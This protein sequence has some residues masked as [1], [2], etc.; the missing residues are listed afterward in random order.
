VQKRSGIPSHHFNLG[1][2]RQIKECRTATGVVILS[3]CIPKIGSNKPADFF[4][5]DCSGGHS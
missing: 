3:L 4:S 5:E 1:P 2:M